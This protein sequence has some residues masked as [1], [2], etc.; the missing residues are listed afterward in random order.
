MLYHK[1]IW[2]TCSTSFGELYN[3]ICEPILLLWWPSC[4]EV[5][6]IQAMCMR[7]HTQA[8][9]FA[10][11]HMCIR[12]ARPLPG[13]DC[14]QADVNGCMYTQGHSDI[15]YISLTQFKIVLIRECN[16]YW[17]LLKTCPSIYALHNNKVYLWCMCTRWC[18]QLLAVVINIII[19]KA[20]FIEITI[21][22]ITARW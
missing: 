18:L 2:D 5:M 14:T 9:N 8:L 20:S 6:I 10:S 19:W 1:S 16:Y 4:S 21:N 22:D 11:P 15:T 13:Q 17:F 7:S 3:Y 12:R